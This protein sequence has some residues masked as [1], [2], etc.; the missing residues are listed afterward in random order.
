MLADFCFVS[1]EEKKG[2]VY[3]DTVP[4]TIS[5]TGT[6]LSKRWQEPARGVNLESNKIELRARLQ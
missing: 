5:N 2:G 1:W 4:G 6:V 3:E